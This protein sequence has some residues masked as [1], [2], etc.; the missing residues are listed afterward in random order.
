MGLMVSIWE[1]YWQPGKEI[2]KVVTEQVSGVDQISDL[3]V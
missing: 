1:D 2:V 3:I